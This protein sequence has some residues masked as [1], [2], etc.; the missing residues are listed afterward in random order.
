V[1]RCNR[2]PVVGGFLQSKRHQSCVF[3]FTY[4]VIAFA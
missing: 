2:M 3:S 4:R 1:Q